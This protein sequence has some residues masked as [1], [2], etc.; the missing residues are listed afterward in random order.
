MPRI[1]T[2]P[3][4]FGG[5]TAEGSSY[6]SFKNEIKKVFKNHEK[7]ESEFGIDVKLFIDKSRVVKN[8]NDLDNFLKPIIDALNEISIIEEHKMDSIKISK[9]RVD[10]SKDEGVDI[11]FFN[12]GNPM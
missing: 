3:V 7:I 4:T 11:S 8:K 2:K 6:W 12:P 1:R 5:P 9:I 10:D